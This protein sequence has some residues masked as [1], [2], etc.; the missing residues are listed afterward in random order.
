MKSIVV[1]EIKCLYSPEEV[2][3]AE[4]DAEVIVA[5]RDGKGNKIFS[6]MRARRIAGRKQWFGTID[7]M[8]KGAQES[9]K[10]P[11]KKEGVHEGGRDQK[12]SSRG[13]GKA[14]KS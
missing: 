13:R 10:K 7:E 5:L 2:R 12:K 8:K 3:N 4:T 9:P 6:P 14:K 1:N 11:T